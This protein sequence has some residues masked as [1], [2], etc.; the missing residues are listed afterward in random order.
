MSISRVRASRTAAIRTFNS[1]HCCE[2]KQL[3]RG[4]R[5]WGRGGGKRDVQFTC[6]VQTGCSVCYGSLGRGDVMDGK[7]VK[8]EGRLRVATR[9]GPP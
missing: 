3:H 8:G 7:N 2:S 9:S 5:G 6:E 1:L 4:V